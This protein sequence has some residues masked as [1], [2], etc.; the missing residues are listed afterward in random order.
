MPPNAHRVRELLTPNAQLLLHQ[1]KTHRHHHQPQEQVSAAR[2]QLQ[3]CVH[4]AILRQ[5]V[6]DPDRG[7]REETEVGGVQEAP[8]ARRYERRRPHR[9][10]RDE[11]KQDQTGRHCR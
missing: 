10:V 5:R 9:H 6:P 4:I 11:E 7:Q 3:L 2:E 8:T 1:T